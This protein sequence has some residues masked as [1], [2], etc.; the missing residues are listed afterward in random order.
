L[1]EELTAGRF[2]GELG[3]R[4]LIGGELGGRRSLRDSAELV[5]SQN[6]GFGKRVTRDQA[7]KH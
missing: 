4:E 3:G 6:A 7:G 5:F 2:V 1:V